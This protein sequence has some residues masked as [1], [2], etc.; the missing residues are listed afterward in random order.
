MWY[1]VYKD[2]P[3]NDLIFFQQ[4]GNTPSACM[5]HMSVIKMEVLFVLHVHNS[6]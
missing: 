1:N 6:G 2:H 5:T 3:S 4:K